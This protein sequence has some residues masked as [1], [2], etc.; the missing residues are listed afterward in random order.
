MFN[1]K[2]DSNT[3]VGLYNVVTIIHFKIKWEMTVVLMREPNYCHSQFLS[4]AL[5]VFTTIFPSLTDQSL[6]ALNVNVKMKTLE[7]CWKEKE[8]EIPSLWI[9]TADTN[10]LK[11]HLNIVLFKISKVLISLSTSQPPHKSDFHIFEQKSI[12]VKPVSSQK[13]N[14][15]PALS[16]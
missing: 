6:D 7:G 8:R 13:A 3:N 12:I 14:I 15:F 11:G 5:P 9:I 1:S 16:E 4:P 10:G 2:S